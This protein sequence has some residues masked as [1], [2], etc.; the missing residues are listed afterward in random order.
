MKDENPL[1]AAFY[2]EQL[3]VLGHAVRKSL[4]PSYAAVL[5][6]DL[7]RVLAKRPSYHSHLPF[8]PVLSLAERRSLATFL[9]YLLGETDG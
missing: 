5:A 4:G 9:D 3:R 7:Y 2:R 6:E 8:A 1:T